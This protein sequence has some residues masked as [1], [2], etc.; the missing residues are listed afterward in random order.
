MTHNNK[1]AAYLTIGLL[2]TTTILAATTTVL[3]DPAVII[4]SYDLSPAVL[5]PGDTALLTIHLKNAELPNTPTTTTGAILN[6][7][8]IT[9]AIDGQRQ[10]YATKTYD[11]VGLLAPAASLD[12]PFVL[13]C[14]QTMPDGLYFITVNVDVNT[15]TDVNYPIAIQ[16]QNTSLSLVAKDAPTT[17][18]QSGTTNITLT[19]SNPRTAEVQSTTITPQPIPGI[20]W[21][22]DH[23]FLGT[24][25]AG[26]TRDVHFSLHAAST[27]PV[28]LTFTASYSTGPNTHTTSLTLPVNVESTLEV[29]PVI[30]GIPSTVAQG[31]KARISL[32]V[33]NAKDVSVSGV[34][35]I[36][37][38]DNMV[39][40]SQYFIGT[41]EPDDV[42]SASF[43]IPTTNLSVGNHDVSF[44]VSYKQGTTYY[45]TPP[46]TAGFTV[47]TANPAGGQGGALLTGAIVFIL[48]ILVVGVFLVWSRRRKKA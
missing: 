26:T 12:L 19:V 31:T 39:Y 27:G 25:A 4:D 42:F 28:N 22:T 14:N 48:I 23:V 41:M 33:Y 8:S 20:T 7:V 45:Q 35:V 21:D 47:T 24:L 36:P 13:R 1:R 32:E 16:V 43:D 15:Y 44:I 5:M 30:A 10:I 29:A 17:F 18:S 2:L 46:V 9:P 34:L 6:S 3:A 40:P 11:D 37:V 38:S